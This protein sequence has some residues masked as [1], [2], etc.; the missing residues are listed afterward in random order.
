MSD[1]VTCSICNKSVSKR[2]SITVDPKDLRKRACKLHPEAQEM[3][4]VLYE[5]E[6]EKHER[7]IKPQF[8]LKNYKEKFI[9]EDALKEEKK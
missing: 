7:H 3:H 8:M 1:Q 5:Q 6:R 2:Q 9:Q 4:K